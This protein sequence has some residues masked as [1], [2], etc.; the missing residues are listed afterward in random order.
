MS[1]F[2]IRKSNM[3]D[4]A[5]ESG[6]EFVLDNKKLIIIILTLMLICGGSFVLGFIEGKRQGAHESNQSA[7]AI[8]PSSLP[9]N[10]PPPATPAVTESQAGAE[11]ERAGSEEQH[12]DWYKSV[13]GQEQEA[14]LDSPKKTAESS[15][16]AKKNPPILHADS[17]TFSVQVGAYRQKHDIEIKAQELRTKGF[18]CRIEPPNPPEQLYFLKVGKFS[19][20]SDAIAIQLRLKKNGFNSFI[21][22][23]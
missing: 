10:A 16:D 23:N 20:R 21:K 1:A 9:E 12:L 8:V 6:L 7:T 2:D 13:N 22:T 14:K 3:A 4:R 18:D 17:I 15:V 5:V 19:S 11:S